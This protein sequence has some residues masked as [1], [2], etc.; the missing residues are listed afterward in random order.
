MSNID[1]N[2][3]ISKQKIEKNTILLLQGKPVNSIL[4][5]HSGMA[6]M[7]SSSG[8]APTHDDSLPSDSGESASDGVRVG[9]IKGET[10]CGIL[11]LFNNKPLEHTVVSVSDC[12]ISNIPV[13]DHMVVHLLQKNMRLN[14][15][16]M[17]ALVQRIESAIYLFKNYKYLWHKLAS[18]QDS[19]ALGSDLENREE[20]RTL[21]DRYNVD[22][23]EYSR[24]LRYELEQRGEKM[25]ETWDSNV[26]LGRIQSGLDLYI[27]YDNLY[28]ENMVDYSQYLFIKRLL[29][30]PDKLVHAL[31]N[32]DEPGNYYVYQFL[33]QSLEQLVGYNEKIVSHIRFLSDILYS[34]QGWVTTVLSMGEEEDYRFRMFRHYLWKFSWRCHRD[35]FKLLHK[36]LTKTH[37]MYQHLLEFRNKPVEE[38]SSDSHDNMFTNDSGQEDASRDGL[39]KYRN[40]LD[41]ILDFADVS[42]EFTEEFRETLNALKELENIY[43]ADPEAEKLRKKLTPMY[44]ELYEICFLKQ[45]NTDLKSFIPGIML[46]FGV[47][48]ETL[49]SGDD[50]EIIDEAYSQMLYVE[51]PLPAMTLPYFLE[52]VYTGDVNP[53]INEMGEGFR[54]TLKRQEKMSNKERESAAHVYQDTP[55]DKV[56]YELR[57]VSIELSKILYGSKRKSLP[58]LTSQ[59]LGGGLSRMLFPPETCSE[60]A[61]KFHSRDYSLFYREVVSKHR[62]GTDIVQKEVL[63]YFVIYPVAGNRMMMWQELDGTRKESPARF[64]IPLYFSEKID[65]GIGNLLAQ[66]RWELSRS[67]AGA[68]W[69]DPVE[70]GLSGAY[71]DYIAFYRKNPKLSS[72]HKEKLKDF[73]KKTRSD[74]D[75]FSSDYITWVLYEYE[76]KV[77]F[78]PVV[79]EIFYRFVPFD[80]QAREQIAKKPLYADLETKLQNRRR[81]EILK[82][83]SRIKKFEKSG[84]TLPREMEDYMEFLKQ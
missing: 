48:D 23:H 70:G 84:E 60:A 80:S 76:G 78:N 8:D 46:H 69:M 15:Q 56:R 57:Q 53:S 65:E 1:L 58:I 25:P 11:G 45:I 22:I 44:W 24:Y 3:R 12:I 10:V 40:L 49:L 7:I 68:N 39:G 33:I 2:Q 81:K 5:I 16:V 52:K 38:S 4:I 30:K 66:F 34:D 28:I 6:E 55:E 77:R 73:I 51:E 35:A 83:E 67:V 64:M 20:P 41:K 63:P 42:E 43:K 31:F 36:D 27:Q 21:P 54:E 75:R 14:I 13:E 72:A 47:V 74:R 17:Q 61:E 26:F 19:L 32:Q 71:Y 37:P 62:F 50:L 59:V 9:L 82:L 79:R 18:I 29:R